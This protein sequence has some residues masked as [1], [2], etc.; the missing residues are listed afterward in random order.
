M[1]N[2]MKAVVN[3]QYGLP[4]VLQLK[5]V[6]KPTPK[7]NEVLIKIHA[8]TVNRTDCG[9]R[10]P[11]YFLVRIIGG[12]FKPKKTILGSE[13][14]GVIE[15]TGKDVKTFK[16]GDS[17]FG[18]ST[19]N[20]GAHAEYICISEEASITTMPSKLSFNEAAA[21]CDGAFLAFT[22][23]RIIDFKKKPKILINGASGSIGTAAVQLAKYYGAE[24]TAVCNTRDF[25]LVKSLGAVKVIDYTK[26]DFTKNGQLY[27]VVFDAVGKSS[28]FRCKKLLN[29]NGM[30]F[31]TELGYLSQNIFLALITPILGGKKVLFPIPK[32]KKEDILFFKELIENGKYRA[33]IDRTYPL[34]EIVEATKFVETGQ[35]T[36]NVVITIERSF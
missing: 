10:N 5:E 33:V 31:S 36:G 7:D 11:E 3:T 9:F 24:I 14:A 25:E 15:A 21:I 12:L 1:N 19:F 23:I 8:T 4:E 6:E 32:D 13:L 17:V 16:P 29:P 20:F 2:K 35:K 28:F 27:D 26:E 18:L 34:D 30:Y 22:Y